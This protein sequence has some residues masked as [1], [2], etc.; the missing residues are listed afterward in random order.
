MPFTT[1]IGRRALIKLLSTGAFIMTT[2][3]GA[4]GAEQMEEPR[5]F[6]VTTPIHVHSAGLRVRDLPMMTDF[7]TRIMGL[8]PIS[9]TEK[10]AVLGKGGAALMTLVSHPDAEPDNKAAAGLY[11]TAFLMPSRKALGEWLIF[12]VRN[13]VP[14][15]GFSDHLVSEALYLDDPEGNGIEVYSDRSP[16]TWKWNNDLVEMAVD[17]LDLDSLVEGLPMEAG[18]SYSA[19]PGFC[20]GH[21]HL[22]VGDV[23]KAEDFYIGVA[24]LERTQ[25]MGRSAT[26]LADGKYHHHLGANV[27]HSRN[28]GLRS[29]RMSGLDF[30]AFSVT[31]PLMDGL[32]RRLKS[33]GI[34]FQEQG[35]AVEALDPWGTRVKFIA[36]PADRS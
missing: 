20:I 18:S 29:D 34:D 15:T 32:H 12:A 5:S 23:D 11:H 17:H 2:G 4:L 8:D 21:M 3:P 28:A 16:L 19:P 30:F 14:F 35:D 7:Y 10:E 33:A 26:F 36:R 1:D 22:R 31:E 13:K 6:A 27:W 9:V 24:G 25:R